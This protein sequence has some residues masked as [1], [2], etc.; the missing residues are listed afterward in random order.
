MYIF[1]VG[2]ILIVFYGYNHERRLTVR[3]EEFESRASGADFYSDGRRTPRGCEWVYDI[4]SAMNERCSD[5]TCFNGQ[6]GP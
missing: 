1:V 6:C 3:S 4:R 2:Y 5:I